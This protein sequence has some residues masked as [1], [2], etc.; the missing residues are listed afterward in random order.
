MTQ[1]RT[2]LC[3]LNMK[4]SDGS[5]AEDTKANDKPVRLVI[6]NE[7]LSPAFE[8]A[9]ADLKQNESQKFT[10]QPEDAF[11]DVQPSQV[12]YMARDRFDPN[13]KLEPGVIML[14]NQPSGEEVPGMIREVVGDSV[15]VDFN[16]PL[17][18]QTIEFTVE[19]LEELH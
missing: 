2:L 8:A 18:G 16:H 5:I 17:A 19:C 1:H 11:G 3:H 4:L 12:H 14:F 6:G 10:L 13:E 7:T 15:I 9:I